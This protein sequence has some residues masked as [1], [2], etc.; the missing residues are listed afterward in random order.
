VSTRDDAF[1]R[2]PKGRYRL[3]KYAAKDKGFDITF[4]DYCAL[5]AQ[6][7][8]YCG[9]PLA[10]TGKGIDRKEPKGAYVL[11]N[12][13]P[14]CGECNVFKGDLFTH[15]EMIVIGAAVAQVKRARTQPHIYR[16]RGPKGTVAS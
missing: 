14:S 5:I 9:F 4:E 10:E 3:L 8:F 7:C 15:E 16:R 6:P 11:G 13:V 12:V 2:T 1:S